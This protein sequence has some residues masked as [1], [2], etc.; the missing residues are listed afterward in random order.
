[1]P[2]FG[3]TALDAN[4]STLKGQLEAATI[5]EAERRLEASGYI[6]IKLRPSKF[7]AGSFTR[8]LATLR[9]SR[10]EII[11][12]VRNLSTI[13]SAGIPL[14]EAVGDTILTTT[15]RE[16]KRSLEEIKKDLL[17]GNT[18]SNA[19]ERQRHI[20]PQIVINL[21]QIGE[22][23][24][25]LD[26]ALRD[27]ADHLQ[28]LEDIAG[29]I[30]RALMYP[31]FALVTTTGALIFWLVYVLPKILVVMK[32]M[33]VKIPLVTR[34]LM[35]VSDFV[36]NKWYITVLFLIT[37][38]IVYFLMQRRPNTK[39]YIDLLKI[40]FPIIKNIVYNKLLA[41]FSEQMRVL[42]SAGIMIDNCFKS[43]AEAMNS[44]V[45]RRAIEHV[46][47]NITQGATIADSLR[48]HSVFP[49]IIVRMTDV[50]EKSGNLDEQFQFLAKYFFERLQSFTE[51]LGKTIEPIL[52]GVV[53]GV[54]A[55]VAIGLLMPL[56]DLITK[57]K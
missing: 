1:M 40:K 33:Q 14:L 55:M 17:Q 25:R 16:L 57:I 4:G 29:M 56:Y 32:D 20:F 12:T 46:R 3:Y 19:L 10:P 24:G 30:K 8:K 11:E 53:G 41:L 15:N 43:T 13:L 48:E 23:T 21:A 2:L 54:F 50:G 37:I 44:E 34:I 27:A 42:I 36:S 18:L 51:K 45:F 35:I 9:V 5:E 7:I 38:W 49:P 31:A 28:R 47:Q 22:T 6:V 52:I 26:L 39:Y